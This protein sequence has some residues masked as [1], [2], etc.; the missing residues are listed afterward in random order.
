MTAAA[1]AAAAAVKKVPFVVS[2]E[3]FR[4][5]FKENLKIF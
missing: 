4:R 3:P 5:S 1:A 2:K